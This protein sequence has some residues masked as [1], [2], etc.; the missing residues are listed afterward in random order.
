MTNLT[1]EWLETDGHGGFASGTVS[2]LRTRRYHGLLFASQK[3][4]LERIALVNGFEASVQTNHGHYFLTS[5]WYAPGTV[6]HDSRHRIESFRSD[7]WPHWIYELEDGT[8]IEHDLFFCRESACL[9]VS[10]RL[11]SS[12][13]STQLFL[14]PLISGRNYHSLHEENTSFNFEPSITRKQIRWDPYKGVP[15]FYS[16]SNG[17]FFADSIWYRHFLYQEEQE[18]GLDAREDLASPGVFKWDLSQRKAVWLLSVNPTWDLE[19]LPEK[20]FDEIVQRENR[21]RQKFAS[22]LLKSADQ[23]IISLKDRRTIIAGYPWFTDWGRDTFI[24]L[25][26]LSISNN[27]L[28]QANEIILEWSKHISEGMVPNFFPESEAKAEYNSV[29]SSLWLIIAIYDLLQKAKK[30]NIAYYENIKQ[31]LFQIIEEILS[32]Y[33]RG[34]RFSIGLDDDGLLK[35]GESGVQLTWMDAKVGD[36][37]ITPRTGKPIEVEALWLNALRISEMYTEK[38]R[39]YFVQGSETFRNRFWNEERGYLFDVID[40]HHIANAN[41]PTLRPNQIFAIGGLPF[42]FYEGERVK[43]ILDLIE[44]EL[45]TPFGLRTL[46]RTEPGYCS[47]YTGNQEQ[48]DR[49]Y[50]QGTVWPWLMGPFVEAWLKARNMTEGAKKEARERFIDPLRSSLDLYGLGHLPEITDAELPFTPRGCPF[51]AWSLAEL[52]R[53]SEIA[54][55]K[56]ATSQP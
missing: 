15:S 12:E 20:I 51:Q 14:R 52:I 13:S 22:R 7:P 18:R 24:S 43:K 25:R 28:E 19:A 27:R 5:Q 44:Q 4:S 46:G 17:E 9:C 8:R 53:I 42:S 11:L 3:N 49:A 16:L 56:A 50:H 37:V 47:N 55:D 35:C 36:Q 23:Y 38:W 39:P 32:A 2:S 6:D 21:S 29:D 31:A 41:D 10:W 54:N 26:G 34:T 1:A 48:R 30:Q 40:C 45:L 33:S